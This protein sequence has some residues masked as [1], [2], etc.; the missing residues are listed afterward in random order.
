MQG[1]DED[2]GRYVVNVLKD[3]HEKLSY[4][5]KYLTP[6]SM[7]SRIA[8][9]RVETLEGVLKEIGIHPWGKKKHKYEKYEKNVN[10][11]INS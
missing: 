11:A 3:T 5:A 9:A 8:L 6:Q 1:S 4:E 10:D 7:F 2:Y